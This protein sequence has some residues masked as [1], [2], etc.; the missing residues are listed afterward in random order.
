MAERYNLLPSEL[1]EECPAYDSKD[2]TQQTPIPKVQVTRRNIYFYVFSAFM[3]FF[4]GALVTIFVLIVFLESYKGFKAEHAVSYENGFQEEGLL[5]PSLIQL[6]QRRFRYPVDFRIEDGS[7]YLVTE[8]GDI[9]YTGK[10]SPEIDRA[11]HELIWGR[12]FSI[13]EE[14]AN[15]LWGD[16]VEAYRDRERSGFTGGFDMFH[17]LHCLNQIRQALHRDYYPEHKIHGVVH[18]EHCINHLRQAIQCA[19]STAVTPN[20]WM[21]GYHHEYVKSNVVHTCRK[22]EPIRDYVKERF[23]G[24]LYV[25]RPKKGVHEFDSVF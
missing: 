2:T 13:S 5:P 12:Y 20:V 21:E 1:R 15:H 22:F 17:Q 25:E 18:L 23:N 8:P 3:L 10:P 24:S 4:S 14:E 11:W 19:A 7:E 9:T 16:Q 6:E